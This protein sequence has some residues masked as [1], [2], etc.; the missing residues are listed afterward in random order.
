MTTDLEFIDRLAAF[1]T[2]VRA[3]GPAAELAR[4][5][6][7]DRHEDFVEALR[8]A[9]QLLRDTRRVIEFEAKE[10]LPSLDEALQH[11]GELLP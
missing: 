7:A 6:V 8:I 11:L 3:G 9:L 1:A 10:L 4:R 5:A 2:A